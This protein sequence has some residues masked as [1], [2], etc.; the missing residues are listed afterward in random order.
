MCHPLSIHSG[1]IPQSCHSTELDSQAACSSFWMTL[2]PNNTPLPF[3][4]KNSSTTLRAQLPDMTLFTN[5]GHPDS[6]PPL[7]TYCR[8]LCLH[9]S[10]SP[11]RDVYLARMLVRPVGASGQQ[12]DLF[13]RKQ[14]PIFT[15]ESEED[16]GQG[17]KQDLRERKS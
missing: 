8:S 1:L 11:S 10:P 6:L 17:R 2:Q 3:P 4:R 9:K 13:P 12:Q 15:A 14:S 5:T 16:G 7:R